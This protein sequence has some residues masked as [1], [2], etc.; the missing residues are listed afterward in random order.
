MFNSFSIFI[1]RSY[2]VSYKQQIPRLIEELTIVAVLEVRWDY[3]C[4]LE[5]YVTHPS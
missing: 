1:E 3:H 2:N 5:A 4:Q